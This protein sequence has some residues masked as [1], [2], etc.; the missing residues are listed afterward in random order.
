MRAAIYVTLL[1]CM[2]SGCAGEIKYYDCEI[3]EKNCTVLPVLV[4]SGKNSVG[5]G[6][7][8]DWGYPLFD[9]E[10]PTIAIHYKSKP[11]ELDKL[12]HLDVKL[13]VDGSEIEADSKEYSATYFSHVSNTLTFE[14]EDCCDGLAQKL[15]INIEPKDLAYSNDLHSVKVVVIKDFKSLGK[16]PERMT[17]VL[18]ATTDKGTTKMERTVILKSRKG[19]DFIRIH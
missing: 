6:I 10:R 1:T 12:I 3:G 5:I 4:G 19:S 14:G 11:S 17:F 13:F 8:T 7:I 15:G 18:T 9:T 2:L 16:L